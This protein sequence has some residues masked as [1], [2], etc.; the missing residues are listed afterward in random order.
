VFE[1]IEDGAERDARG[2]DQGDLRLAVVTDAGE[3]AKLRNEWSA[4]ATDDPT[5]NVYLTWEWVHTW[6]RHFSQGNDLHVIVVRDSEGIVAIAPFQ[7]SRLGIG[8]WATHVLQ[9]IS[10]E[11]GD[12]GGVV[13]VRRHA[14]AVGLIVDDLEQALRDRWVDVV[15][16]SRLLDDD[17]FLS[18]LREALAGRSG[19][20]VVSEAELDGACLFTDVRDGFQLATQA[21]KHRIARR[22][23]RLGE[24]HGSVDFDYHSGDDLD[25][26]LSRLL[27]LHARR[28]AGRESDVRGLLADPVREAFLVEAVRALDG[29]G[30]VRLLTLTAG[31]RLVAAELDF[32]YRRRL[33]MFKGA[34]DPGHGSYGPGQ[35]LFH[36]VIEDGLAAGVEVVD[37]GRG[38]QP[39]KRRWANGE[40]RQVAVTLTTRS[41]AGRLNAYRLRAARIVER[42]LG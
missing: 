35:L 38:D 14:E 37:W 13:L 11:A 41:M 10:P 24:E 15:V 30:W 18:S 17:P 25:D 22:L 5:P 29:Q 19:S 2:D 1:H 3:L 34:F 26:G 28:W 23:Q 31:G 33:F 12:Y 16:I 20:L 36:R 21:K 9:R 27:E 7:R 6:W 32:E 40:R 8:P 39:Y 4:A 42:R